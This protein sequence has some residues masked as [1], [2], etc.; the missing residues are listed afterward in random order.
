MWRKGIHEPF[1]QFGYK[2][3]CKEDS[4]DIV[5]T[6]FLLQKYILESK[7]SKVRFSSAPTAYFA[8][9][10]LKRWRIVATCARVALPKGIT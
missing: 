1:G 3:E 4:D 7:L 6:L 10:W 5:G 9:F 8:T 2:P